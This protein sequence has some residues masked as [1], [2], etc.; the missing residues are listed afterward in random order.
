MQ[1]GWI[2]TFPS[3]NGTNSC[4]DVTLNSTNIIINDIMAN[5][6]FSILK[7][8]YSPNNRLRRPLIIVDKGL[9]SFRIVDAQA[10]DVGNI[11]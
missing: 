2:Q 10:V 11:M 7:T 3:N 4:H 5:N 6:K 9:V 8:L 1:D